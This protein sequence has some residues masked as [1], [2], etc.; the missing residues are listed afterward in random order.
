MDLSQRVQAHLRFILTFDV[1]F[2]MSTSIRTILRQFEVKNTQVAYGHFV[3]SFVIVLICFFLNYQ[4]TLRSRY[5]L[6]IIFQLL[7]V[8]FLVKLFMV[9]HDCAHQN[10][11]KSNRLNK[12]VCNWIYHVG[13]IGAMEYYS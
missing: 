1:D 11:F 3:V 12:L 2:L 4:F 6:L 8:L 5:L 13:A 10:Y 7:Q 9:F